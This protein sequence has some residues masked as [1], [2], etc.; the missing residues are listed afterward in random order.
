MLENNRVGDLLREF[1]ED[2]QF[3]F[4]EMILA[5]QRGYADYVY[6]TDKAD[7]QQRRIKNLA[8]SFRRMDYF[9]IMPL[10]QELAVAIATWQYEAPYDFYD[11][12]ADEEDLAELLSQEAREGRYFA[13]IRNGAL[14]GYFCLEWD[15]AGHGAELGLGMNPLYTG[16][17]QGI[18]FYQTI[19][20]YI[21]TNYP[22]CR[23]LDLAVA[24]FNGRARHLYQAVGF[25][26]QESYLQETNGGHYPFV[27]MTKQLSQPSDAE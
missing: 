21:R 25:T 9:Y 19:E 5:Y 13:V 24:D 22:A 1:P 6:K 16:K 26:E 2:V 17:G 4:Q 15:A 27:K 14:M 12:R 8:K 3:I 20:D 10:D 23:Q 18:A 7:V 11:A